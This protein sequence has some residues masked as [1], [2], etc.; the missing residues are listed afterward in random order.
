M[1][2]DELVSQDELSP[3]QLAFAKRMHA[4]P[5]LRG[6]LP[7][8]TVFLYRE[9]RWSVSRWL[10]DADGQVLEATTFHKSPP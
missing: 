8:S 6:T 4:T 10:V 3:A 2:T 7:E 9:D 1:G 5:G